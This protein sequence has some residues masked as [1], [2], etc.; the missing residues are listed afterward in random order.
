MAVLFS[1]LWCRWQHSLGT[2]RGAGSAFKLSDKKK[3][4]GPPW[5]EFYSAWLS[6]MVFILH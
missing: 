6:I 5:L 1:R 4:I 3:G 2:E